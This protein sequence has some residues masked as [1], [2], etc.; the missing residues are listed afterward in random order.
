MK[1]DVWIKSYGL[2]KIFK[3][4]RV[5]NAYR[6]RRTV[7]RVF[8]APR[9]LETVQYMSRMNALGLLIPK[10]TLGSEIG[11]LDQELRC[12]IHLRGPTD[13]EVSEVEKATCSDVDAD[14]TY[15][16]HMYGQHSP[17]R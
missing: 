6:G 3:I 1:S 12:Y 9:V 15:V 17:P 4:T 13:F 16:Q 8:E 10:V 11:S 2:L 5:K 14:K 7:R